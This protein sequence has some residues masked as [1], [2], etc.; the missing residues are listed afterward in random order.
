MR[1]WTLHPKYLDSRGLV[2]LWRE[3][4]LAQKVLAG[5]TR[6]YRHH[7]Q[8]ERFKVHVDPRAAIACYLWHITDEATKRGY[9]FDTRRIARSRTEITLKATSGQLA[10]EWQHLKAKLAVRDPELLA[11]LS[12]LV[13]PRAHP[14]FHMVSGTIADWER[15]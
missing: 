14:M 4:L 5:K 2:A 11:T 8:L 6:G 1:I 7:P 10:H 12:G 9:S 15:A 13:R 3:T